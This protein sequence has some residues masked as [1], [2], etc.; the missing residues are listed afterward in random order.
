MTTPDPASP[1]KPAAESSRDHGSGAAETLV[2]TSLFTLGVDP[3]L[4]LVDQNSS[5]DK[6]GLPLGDSE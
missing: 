2:D 6:S 5:S 3:A 4:S 1:K